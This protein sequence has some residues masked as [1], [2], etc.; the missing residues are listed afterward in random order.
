MLLMTLLTYFK[1]KPVGR[2]ACGN[3][4]FE[5]KFLF[6][7][8]NRAPR[9]WVLYKGEA[10]ASKIPAEWHGWLHFTYEDPLKG[11][12]KSWQKKHLRNLTGTDLAYMP[13]TS[14]TKLFGQRCLA[15]KPYETWSPP[16]DSSSGTGDEAPTT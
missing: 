11:P 12:P 10:E 1:G 15:R 7:K 14:L 9:R 6:S 16:E 4:Y 5:E 3:E 8:P 13:P 2:D